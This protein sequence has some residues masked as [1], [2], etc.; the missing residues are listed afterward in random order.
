M[1]AT[2][3]YNPEQS[4]MAQKPVLKNPAAQALGRLG[5]SAGTKAQNKARKQNAKL[6][7]RPRRVCT[8]CGEPVSGGHTDRTL[9]ETCGAHGWKWEQGGRDVDAPP[10]PVI[11]LLR[12]A[13]AIIESGDPTNAPSKQWL[14]AARKVVA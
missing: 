7:G 9:D 4:D 1:N 2:I 14:R 13:I 11:D 8:H 12:D 6:G 3:G 10:N 5:G